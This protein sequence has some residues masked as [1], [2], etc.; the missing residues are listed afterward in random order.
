[1]AVAEA[2]KYREELEENQRMIRQMV[3]DSLE[4]VKA[5]KGRDYNEFF[6]E[7]EKRYQNA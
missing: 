3:K 7:L 1:M 6:D 5:G 2:L 4:D